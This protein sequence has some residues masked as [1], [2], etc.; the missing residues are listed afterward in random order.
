MVRTARAHQLDALFVN[1]G[2]R[3]RT[4]QAL[5]STLAAIEPPIWAGLMAAFIR[6]RGYSVAILDADAENLGPDE[7]AEAI[8]EM[9]PLLT[10]IVVYGQNPSA[11]TPLM[12]HAGAI[13]KAMTV[14]VPGIPSM[15]VGGHV[16]ALPERTLR[17]ENATF[18]AGGE[19]L[20]TILDLIRVLK[21][22]SSDYRTVRGLWFRD[23]AHIQSNPSAPLVMDLDSEMPAVAWDLLPMAKYRAHNWHCFGDV[24]R[25]PYAA[26]YTTLGCPFHCSFCCIQAPFRD[27]ENVLGYK[28]GVSSYR[29]WS[30]QA[31]IDQIDLLVNR[32]SVRN[33]KFADEL[34]AAN[35]RHVMGICDLITSRGYDLNIWAYARVDTLKPSML[36]AM[37]KAGINWLGLG[38]ESAN[39]RV[40]ADVHR[41]YTQQR[42]FEAIEP[43]RGEGIYVG[44]NYIFGLP[45]D[46]HTSM[47]QTLDLALE[48]NSEWA[49]F[50]CAMA[51]PGSYLYDQ[52]LRDGWALPRTWDGYSQYAVDTLPLSTKYLSSGEVLQ[53]RDDAF[54]VYFNNPGYL[55]MITKR[56]G[57]KTT[58]HIEEMVSYRLQRAHAPVSGG[59]RWR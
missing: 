42:I 39:A 1:P 26:L 47:Q 46:D 5:A 9:K 51:Y 59:V 13:C 10:V 18:V 27:G 50:Y 48:I 22:D 28:A 24:E 58:Q 56:Y 32:Y 35:P 19:G 43:I 33:I 38:I 30:P 41:D 15:L 12:S 29:F 40:R 14:R 53:F 2:G 8:A 37:K 23:G 55:E 4:Y 21:S 34:F 57:V 20:Y 36:A 31:V 45:E 17:E 6:R 52:A 25:Q 7:A 16:A 49:N 3:V 54:Q 11:S 44:A